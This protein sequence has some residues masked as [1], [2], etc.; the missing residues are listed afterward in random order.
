MPAKSWTLLDQGFF[1]MNPVV[2][3]EAISDDDLPGLGD[4]GVM[5]RT[6]RGGLADGVF[7]VEINTGKALF[8]VLPTRGMGVWRAHL[9]TPQGW[10][11]IGWKSPVSGPVHPAFVDLGEPSGLGW[12]DGFDELLCRCGTLLL[13][14]IRDGL[15]R[16]M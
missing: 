14:A 13:R 11:L 7:S 12:L 2:A 1:G 4:A 16:D 10:E 5:T 15:A 9:K 8:N 6:W 3:P